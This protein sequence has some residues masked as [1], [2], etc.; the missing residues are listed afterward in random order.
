MIIL[1]LADIHGAM[2]HGRYAYLKLSDRIE[3]LEIR[4][5]P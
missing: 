2:H 1:G 5:M 4:E 3:A